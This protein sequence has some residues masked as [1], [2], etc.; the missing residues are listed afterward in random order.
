[1]IDVDHAQAMK[2]WR[3]KLGL[4]QARAATV[5]GCSRALIALTEIG[6]NRIVGPRQRRMEATL[7]AYEA[8]G[9][10]AVEALGAF[11]C[12]RLRRGRTPVPPEDRETMATWRRGVGFS[13]WEAADDLGL[14][15]HSI[16]AIER[17]L[18]RI[19]ER[20]RANMR[21]GA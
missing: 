10:E 1:M 11:R 15:I 16:R 18:M 14:S 3:K 13:L 20:V 8:G 21:R 17:G 6:K 2:W 5:L 19:T 12:V 7:A 9:M 4:S